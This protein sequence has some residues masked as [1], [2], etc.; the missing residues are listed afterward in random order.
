MKSL[1]IVAATIATILFVG[2]GN[3]NLNAPS[4]AGAV[5]PNGSPRSA[6]LRSGIDDLLYVASGNKGIYVYSLD[7]TRKF[8]ITATPEAMSVAFDMLGKLYAL[9]GSCIGHVNQTLDEYTP[10]LSKKSKPNV[11][12]EHIC[13]SNHNAIGLYKKNLLVANRRASSSDLGSVVEYS[14]SSASVTATI[15]KGINNPQAIAFDPANNLEVADCP[16]C[17][18]G[19][20]SNGS[21]VLYPLRFDG[22]F[23]SEPTSIIT[24]GID[25]PDA[26]A[27]NQLGYLY[28]SNAG[29]G[30][31][32]VYLA[33]KLMASLSIKDLKDP[34]SLTFDPGNDLYIGSNKLG[35]TGTVDKYQVFHNIPSLQI[36]Q[37]IDLPVATT[38]DALGNLYVAN[39]GGDTV[40]SY[41]QIGRLRFT[42]RKVPDPT[43][44]TVHP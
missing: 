37:G 5:S 30:T 38:T 44:V 41:N 32:T 11:T 21:I 18:G 36:T 16:S 2:C 3:G 19:T 7:G 42:A 28:V 39:G 22:T 25:Q 24:E 14:P 43:D 1:P 34:V 20:G 8:L 29:N 12:I 15:T 10:P 17:N 4:L 13:A 40:T 31:V 35:N 27:F 23:A 33:G 9:N 6:A 26:I